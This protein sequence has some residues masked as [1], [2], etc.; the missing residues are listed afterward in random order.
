VKALSTMCDT[1]AGGAICKEMH[2]GRFVPVNES[3]F[4]DDVK[5]YG[6]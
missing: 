1:K 4:N 3:L 6:E 2:I 5:R